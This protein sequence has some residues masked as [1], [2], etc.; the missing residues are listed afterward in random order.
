MPPRIIIKRTDA[1]WRVDILRQHLT[2]D[3]Q[4]DI[5]DSGDRD[6]MQTALRSATAIVSMNWAAEMPPAPSLKLLHLPGAG[7]DEIIWSALP[8]HVTVCNVF[9]HEIGIAEFV[10]AA[11]LEWCIRI[12]ELQRRFRSEFHWQGSHLLGPQHAELFR[13]TV[14]IVGYGRIGSEVARRCHAF[15]MRVLACTR[16]PKDQDPFAERVA[17]I[18]SLHEVLAEADFVVDALPLDQHTRGIFDAPAFRAM[19]P[20]A[21][22]INVGRG[23]TIDEQALFEALRERRIGG[24]VID[25][26]YSYPKPGEN[27]ARPSEFPF[28]TLDNIIM[29]P[30]ASAWSEGLL[31]RRWSMIANNLNR[32]AR[33]EPLINVVR[34]GA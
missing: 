28:E 2:T 7:L 9:E 26:W 18:A 33:S 32:L 17:P 3:W 21:V 19:R 20:S 30:H 23:A 14:A 11:M 31:P 25:V 12:T 16:S 6:A 8:P 1:D 34:P 27:I 5:I 13:K 4:V 10:L 29:T 15:G 22:L 24:A